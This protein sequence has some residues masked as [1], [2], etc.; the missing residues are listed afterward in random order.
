MSIVIE[1]ESDDSG[2]SVHLGESRPAQQQQQQQPRIHVRKTA[3]SGSSG[4]AVIEVRRDLPAQRQQQQ[5]QRPYRPPLQYNRP[6]M[7]PRYQPPSMVR[8]QQQPPPRPPPQQQ[9]GL[10]DFINPRKRAPQQYMNGAD[11][12]TVD[13]AASIS[14]PSDD[15]DELG[16]YGGMMVNEGLDETTPAVPVAPSPGFKTIDEEKQDIIFKLHRLKQQGFAT[17]RT[18]TLAS[19][20]MEMRTELQKVKYGIELDASIKF[21]RK[22]LMACVSTL[23]FMNKKY[24]PFDLALNGWSENVMENIND[25]D[26]VFEKLY[27]KY[28]HK[29]AMPPEVE[30]ILMVGGS[31]F[32]F[33]L[34][35]SMFKRASVEDIVKSHPELAKAAMQSQQQQQGGS[36]AADNAAAAPQQQQHYNEQQPVMQQPDLGKLGFDAQF[37][38]MGVVPSNPIPVLQPPVM[39]NEP[40]KAPPETVAKAAAP[41][42]RRPAPAPSVVSSRFSDVASED[43]ESVPDNLSEVGADI[44]HVSVTGKRKPAKRGPARKSDKKVVQI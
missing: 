39:A 20:I 22:I 4:G 42:A 8:P 29:V 17:S 12:A 34:T 30:L 24:D 15:D 19:D 32:M 16:D 26:D 7:Q 14:I 9:V 13:D 21:S 25:Y 27:S 31:A 10:D 44:K 35:N 37:A 6:V 2:I 5:Q 36:G 11:A 23:E 3:D 28:R 33:H 43:L 41:P 40:R 1:R 18:F 38:P